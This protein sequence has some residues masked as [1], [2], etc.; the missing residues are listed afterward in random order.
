MYAG[1]SGNG[2]ADHSTFDEIWVLALPAFRWF[3]A[4][5]P[6]RYPRYGHT[7]HVV[8][9][10]QMLTI[11][12]VNASG[13]DPVE[14]WYSPDSFTQGIGVFDMTEMRWASS[15]DATAAPYAQPVVVR[16]WYNE[17][18]VGTLHTINTTSV[19]TLIK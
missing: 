9:N 11:G 16:A 5:Y 3:R 15:Y 8:G 12:G 7:C 18:Y 2:G 17:K 19:L 6:A 4:E 14:V 1:W 13:S 10:R